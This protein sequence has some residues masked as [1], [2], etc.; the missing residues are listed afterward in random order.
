[1]RTE[2]SKTKLRLT[3]SG[4]ARLAL[5]KVPEP[6]GTCQWLTGDA[7]RFLELSK[8]PGGCT[9]DPTWFR[10][11]SHMVENGLGGGCY[12]ERRGLGAVRRELCNLN[13]QRK[14][15]SSLL[16]SGKKATTAH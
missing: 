12:K 13:F 4:Q 15:S 7:L 11:W 3:K 9:L 5:V 2:L 6:R 10:R 14:I 1:M 8:A 16:S